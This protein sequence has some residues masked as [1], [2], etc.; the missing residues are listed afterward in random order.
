MIGRVFKTAWFAKKAKKAL[1][2]DQEL[3]EAISQVMLNQA[4]NLGGGVYKKRLKNNMYRSIIVANC[5]SF[6]VYEYLFAKNDREN[7]DDRELQTFKKLAK[8]YSE[9]TNQQLD[10]LI[11]GKDLVEIC[12]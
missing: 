5:G 10:L 9:I 2:C 4:D 12:V 6:W 1:I 7:I 11:H 3:C 8:A